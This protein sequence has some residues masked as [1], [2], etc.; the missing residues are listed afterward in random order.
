M[1][2]LASC[3]ATVLMGVLMGALLGACTDPTEIQV[4]LVAPQTCASGVTLNSPSE[5][6]LACGASVVERIT[7]DADGAVLHEECALLP[8][9]PDGAATLADVP[10]VL[11]GF[12]SPTI[13][14]GTTI[15]VEVTIAGLTTA[16]G[17][18]SAGCADEP[19]GAGAN[20]SGVSAPVRL[21]SA[22]E[23]IRVP[24]TCSAEPC[25]NN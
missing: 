22:T 13:A 12:D 20:I 4:V 2:R 11:T 8:T 10:A 16:G 5:V 15:R 18:G 14:D 6:S 23:V 25:P 21:G 7:K 3:L 24:L 19:T 17:G 9:E 1:A